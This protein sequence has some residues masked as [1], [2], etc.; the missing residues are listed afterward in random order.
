MLQNRSPRQT[1]DSSVQAVIG[2]SVPE[3]ARGEEDENDIVRSA[4][5][6]YNMRITA[7]MSTEMNGHSSF[8]KK[9][10]K[11]VVNTNF[12]PLPPPPNF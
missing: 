10:E 8:G 5:A 1:Y 2:Q 12:C 3:S 11:L 9:L 7:R 6:C 4:R